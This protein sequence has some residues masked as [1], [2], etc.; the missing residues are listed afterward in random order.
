MERSD[1]SPVEQRG[2]DSS[3][4]IVMFMLC[5]LEAKGFIHDTKYN[6]LTEKGKILLWLFRKFEF[7]DENI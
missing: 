4:G 1:F 5:Q 6:Q 2:D 7:I 3:S